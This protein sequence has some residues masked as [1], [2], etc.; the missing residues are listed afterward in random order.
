[1]AEQIFHVGIKAIVVNS[2]DEIP[3]LKEVFPD[4]GMQWDVPGGRM[5]PGETF[6]QTL[7]RELHEEIGVEEYTT[8]EHFSTALSNKQIKTEH[9]PVALVLVVYRVTLPKDAS[10]IAVE[11]GVE[12]SWQPVE[13]ATKLLLDK[14]PPEFVNKLAVRKKGLAR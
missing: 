7:T 10:P 11:E 4:G 5:D 1:M 2:D 13:V 8:A 14:Y 6:L 9:G 3:M 12:L